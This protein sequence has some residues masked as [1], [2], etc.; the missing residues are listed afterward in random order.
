MFMDDNAPPHGVRIVTA[1]LLK[2]GD[3]LKQTLDDVC[4]HVHSRRPINHVHFNNACQ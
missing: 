2:V 1:G 3:Q 4:A